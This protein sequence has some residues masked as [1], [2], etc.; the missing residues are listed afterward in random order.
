MRTLCRPGHTGAAFRGTAAHT[1]AT[2]TRQHGASAY[3]RRIFWI[4]RRVKSR[5]G[6]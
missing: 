6:R 4:I 1:A 5:P 3:G 2:D